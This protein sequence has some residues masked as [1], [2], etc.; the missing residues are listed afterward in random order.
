MPK[1]ILLFLTCWLNFSVIAQDLIIANKRNL[2]MPNINQ[3]TDK[4]LETERVY[5]KSDLSLSMY[6]LGIGTL[7]VNYVV[8]G[9]HSCTRLKQS[10]KIKVFINS[11]SDSA[12]LLQEINVFKLKQD[13]RRLYRFTEFKKWNTFTGNTY[14]DND[15]VVFIINKKGDNLYSIEFQTNLSAGEYAIRLPGNTDSLK[16]FGID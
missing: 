16:L 11:K 14:A 7:K 3:L 13:N 8:P 12:T 4:V 1:A 6:L 15:T 5:I 10:E 9:L 2:V